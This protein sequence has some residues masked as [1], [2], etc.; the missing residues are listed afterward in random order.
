MYSDM[1]P[2]CLIMHYLFFIFIFTCVIYFDM[3]LWCL[4]THLNCMHVHVNILA[5][6][7]NIT[8]NVVFSMLGIEMPAY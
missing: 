1:V 2:W 6:K 5:I 7:K 4:I 8:K 3:V